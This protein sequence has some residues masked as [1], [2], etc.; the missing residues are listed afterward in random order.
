M[1]ANASSTADGSAGGGEL[2][3][4]SSGEG[5]LPAHLLKGYH[6]ILWCSRRCVP[7]SRREPPIHCSGGVGILR[8][9]LLILK[10]LLLSLQ[11]F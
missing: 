8:G 1:D 3:P 6:N 11:T 9:K 7:T 5:A 4:P 10:T 2:L